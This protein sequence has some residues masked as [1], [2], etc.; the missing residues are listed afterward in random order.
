VTRIPVAAACS[1]L[2]LAVAAP[3][4]AQQKGKKHVSTPPSGTLLPAPAV[5]GATTTGAVPFAWIDDASLLAPGRMSVSM[6]TLFWQ[7]T[8][9]NEVDAPIVGVAL[10][11]ADRVQIAA[12]I[13]RVAGRGDAGGVVGGLGTTFVSAKVGVLTDAE[14]GVKLAVAPTL[15]ILGESALQALGTGVGRTQF[16]LPVS[17]EIVSNGTRV[18]GSAGYFSSGVWFAGGGIGGQLTPRVALSAAFSS[19]WLH[20]AA[21]TAARDRKELSGGVAFAATPRISLFG[22]LGTTIGTTDDNGAGNTL[23]GGILFRLPSADK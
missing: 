13:P 1:V 12:S 21:G 9:V 3:V 19:A 17:A 8:D 7:G 15:E 23:S 5:T 2:L 16:G 20:G 4:V 11:V 14:S 18:F 22:S 6:S 10:G